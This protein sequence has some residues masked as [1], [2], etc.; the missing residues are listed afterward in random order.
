MNI[1]VCDRVTKVFGEGDQASTVLSSVSVTFKQ[2]TAYALMGISGSGKSTFLSLLAGLEEPTS[3]TIFFN[4]RKV[5]ELA[6]RMPRIFFHQNIGIIFQKA[7]LLKELSVIENVILKGLIAGESFAAARKRGQELLECVGLLHKADNP[8]FTLSGGEQ[9]RVAVVR[10]L[11]TRPLFLL[12]DEP[13][14]HL[15]LVAKKMVIALLLE[16]TKQTGTG[17]I[18]TCHDPMV[19]ESMDTKMYLKQA[20]LEQAI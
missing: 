2:G 12:A 17:L 1:L 11:F 5:T 19:A 8:S 3:G 20:S 16:Y 10:A 15:D 6:A 14:A 9:Q 4:D 7:H 18:V 13:T